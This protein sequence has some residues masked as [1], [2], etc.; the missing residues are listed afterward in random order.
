MRTII[1]TAAFCG[2]LL[3]PGVASAAD[4]WGLPEEEIV[5]FDAKV[6]DLL[7]ELTGDCPADCGAGKRQLGLLTGEGTLVLPV[8]NATPFSGA[9]DELIEFCGKDVTADGLFS[10]NRG[11]KVFALQFVREAPDGKWRRANRF[12]PKWAEANGFDPKGEEVKQWFRNDPEVRA[13]LAADG[14]LGLG[15]EADEAYRKSQE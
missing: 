8:K 12:L 11:Y 4:S 3:A 5:R 13:V 6:V 10:T 9:A 14:V 7:C 15:P 2:L 1:K